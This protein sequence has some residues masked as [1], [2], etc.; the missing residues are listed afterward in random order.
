MQLFLEF[1]KEF[2]QGEQVEGTT[3]RG[4]TYAIRSRLK[5]TSRA[6]RTMTAAS[7]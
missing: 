1:V 3:F 5:K 4:K 7:A 2:P 6:K